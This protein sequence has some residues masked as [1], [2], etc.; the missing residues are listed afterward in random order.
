MK[1]PSGLFVQHAVGRG[2]VVL[3][4]DGEVLLPPVL[5]PLLE[6]SFPFFSVTQSNV[7][8]NSWF[9][10]AQRFTAGVAV[11]ST[12]DIGELVSGVWSLLINYAWQ[13][14]GTT[15]TA[16]QFSILLLDPA[17]NNRPLVAL[18]F[19]T[20]AMYGGNQMFWIACN[21]TLTIRMVIP[22][23]IAGDTAFANCAVVAKKVF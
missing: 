13:F 15:D 19:F 16:K 20:G 4:N 11:A 7:Q 14:T 2:G 10:T 6:I 3:Q 1:F 12:D 5:Q 21:T 8:G 23:R 22:A 9:Q 17:A 18:P